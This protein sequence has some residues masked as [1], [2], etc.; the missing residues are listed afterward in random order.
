MPGGYLQLAFHV[1]DRRNHKT[2]G[3]GHDG[4]SLDVYWLRS[5]GSTRC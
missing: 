2:Q 4:I 3:H 1:G 5:N